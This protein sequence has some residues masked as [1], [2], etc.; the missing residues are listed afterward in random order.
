MLSIVV[1]NSDGADY[2]LQCL[3]SIY[4]HPPHDAFEVILVDNQSRDDCLKRVYTSL[5]QVRT[6]S[7]P[8]RQGFA[9]NYNLGIRHANGEFIMILN[10][11]TVVHA[12]ALD[13]L[14]NALRTHPPYGIVGPKLLSGEGHIQTFCARPLLT[15][16][17]YILELL[18][19]DL[20]LPTGRWYDALRQVRVA[21]RPSGPVPSIN[22][23]CMMLSRETLE[24]VGPLDQRY[25]F[26]FEDVEWCH[27]IQTRGYQVAYIAEAVITH[28][29]N[30][31]L[32]KV[33]EWAK[34]SEY[35]S[36]LR[37]FRQCYSISLWQMR[38][39]WITT[40]AS[41]LSRWVAFQFLETLL[42]RPGY[43]QA[44]GNL[45]RWIARQ[46]PDRLPDDEPATT[47]IADSVE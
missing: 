43:S 16:F 12:G 23:A 25:D 33:K 17:R 27:R 24:R 45:S 47:M 44:Y 36:A 6:C 2:T 11:D 42:R 15:P 46:Y 22:G 29:G 30:Q 10:N 19:L 38:L 35:K 39:L 18:F 20:G 28:F 37:Y 8:V 14:L 26:Y 7:A 13:A 5:P 34:Q 4:H 41:Y 1:V 31:S 9:K 21:T 40:A 3:G 32:S